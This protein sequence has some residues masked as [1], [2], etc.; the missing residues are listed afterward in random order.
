MAYEAIKTYNVSVATSDI[1][2]SWMSSSEPRVASGGS[3][4]IVSIASQNGEIQNGAGQISFILPANMGSGFLVSGSAYIKLQ[5]S[6]TQATA[7]AWSFKQYGSASSLVLR[8]SLL[9][10]GV[11]AEQIQNYNKLYSS[12]LLHASNTTYL[13]NDSYLEEN[14]LP[15]AFNTVQTLD[16]CIPVGLGLVNSRQHLP[17]FLLSSCQLQ[18]DLDSTLNAITQGNNAGGTA[19]AVSG[20]T[21]R[22]ATLVF[23]QLVPDS[24]FEMSVKQMLATRVYQ[25]PFNSW[26]NIKLAQTGTIN[27]QISLNSSSVLAVM[28]NN[29]TREGQ[30]DA[31]HFT[32][33]NQVSAYLYLDGQLVCNSNL[34]SVPEQFLEMNRCL[35]S[36]FDSS[37]TSVG[38]AANTNG[39]AV[40]ND[41]TLA[42]LTRDNYSN[43][44]YLGGIST[45]RSN[46]AGF[47]FQGS[48]VNS[49]N[50]QVTCDAG[51]TC[52]IYTAL[53]MVATIDAMG[54]VNL[55]R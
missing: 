4:R 6:V 29:V 47:S 15:G 44:V 7:Y 21:V 35:N 30:K 50:L 2:N 12:L 55:I 32:S 5:V 10:S 9:M 23:E 8:K 34:S 13:E 11:L 26:Y 46:E 33:S 42:R 19:G 16:V 38:V 48:P 20:H 3:R 40:A 54:S 52:Y 45:M 36:A 24:Q 27:Q 25:I 17:L 18:V 28:W 31:S 49:A 37:R 51:G 1:P 53:Q 39:D 14:T 43:G 41:F 22:N